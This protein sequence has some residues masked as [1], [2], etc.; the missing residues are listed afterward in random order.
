MTNAIWALALLV[1]IFRVYLGFTV[2]PT[3]LTLTGTYQA[4]AHILVGMFIVL[5]CQGKKHMVQVLLLLCAVE[6]IVA[7]ASRFFV[8][9]H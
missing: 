2:A 6:V 8:L 4:F 7:T 9:T 3:V 1:C 5:A